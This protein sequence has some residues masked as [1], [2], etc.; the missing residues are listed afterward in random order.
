MGYLWSSDRNT[1]CYTGGDKARNNTLRQGD[2][3][4]QKDVLIHKYKFQLYSSRADN[5][6][7]TNKHASIYTSI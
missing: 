5:K 4:S 3:K 7:T 1:H 2:A 6:E